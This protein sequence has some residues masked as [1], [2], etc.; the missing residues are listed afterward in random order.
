M[1]I[2]IG[3]D[4]WAPQVNGVVTTLT[5]TRDELIAQGHTVLMITPEGRR[6]FPCPT[7]PEIRLVLF[8]YRRVKREIE[9][10]RP[11][12]I[13]IATEG[14]IGLAVRKYAIRKGLP[15]TT[16]YH[17]QYPEYV[18]ARTPVPIRWTAALLRR[19]H[20]RAQRTL[21]PTENIRRVLEERGFNNLVTWSRGVDTSVFNPTKPLVYDLPR[22][23]WIN[24]GRVSVEKNIEAFLEL[25]L[26]GSKVIVGDGPDLERLSKQY[27]DAHFVG[28]QFGQTL[29]S[30]L[31][32][33]DVFVFPSKTDTF[34]I[35]M[36]EA[37][38][39]GLPVAAFP[40]PGPI[41]VVDD[42]ITGSLN[43]KLRHACATAITLNPKSC[44]RNARSYSWH[45]C[46]EQFASHLEPRRRPRPRRMARHQSASSTT[47]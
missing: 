47:R 37:M 12:C 26:P 14:T 41:D 25:D 3:T 39:C 19:F 5:Q 4:A 31:A 7:Y 23:V 18:R 30:F 28:Y 20:R 13:H 27:P 32:G 46:T 36:L 8:P 2:L 10:F 45:R 44:I 22:P 29:A 11:D 42:G 9:A 1:R 43:E 21:V 38:A 40:V 6:S 17:T 24:V 15:F 35:V 34:G 16:A 33:A